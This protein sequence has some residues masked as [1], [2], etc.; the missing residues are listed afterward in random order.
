MLEITTCSD[1]SLAINCHFTDTFE[2]TLKH[3]LK[4][5]CCLNVNTNIIVKKKKKTAN[6]AAFYSRISKITTIL[7][8]KNVIYL[9]VLASLRNP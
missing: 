8:V 7:V 4:I 1:H 2:L 9:P 3:E 5:A 6:N